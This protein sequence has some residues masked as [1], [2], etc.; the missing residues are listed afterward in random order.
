[1]YVIIFQRKQI[2]P[3]ILFFA[4]RSEVNLASPTLDSED[5]AFHPNCAAS[6]KLTVLITV[7][8]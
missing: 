3:T 1:M 2:D 7:S 5:K 4:L 6:G 8:I